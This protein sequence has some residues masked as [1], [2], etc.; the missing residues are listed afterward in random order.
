MN[1]LR[2]L[3]NFHKVVMTIVYSVIYT[4]G[5]VLF[6]NNANLISTGVAGI[7]QIV[8]DVINRFG[9]GS[10]YG[11]VYLILNIP[12]I[13]LGWYK[14][15]RKFTFYS[16]LSIVTVT[17][18]SNM[19]PEIEVSKDLIM[20]AIFGGA[21]MGFG[22]G[23]L[24]KIGGSSG[25]TDFYGIYLY[26]KFGMDFTRINTL[27]NVVIIAVATFLYG[28]EI[29]LYTILS[30]YVRTVALDQVFTNNNKITVWIIGEDLSKVS[31]YIN[32]YLKH[33][34]TIINNVEGGYTRQHKEIIM[35]IL[36]Q[37]EYSM[38]V[39]DIYKIDP[40]VFINVTE[41][42]DV[43]GNFKRVKEEV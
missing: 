19:V 31:Q 40:T 9:I 38:L 1:K 10:T 7:A 13:V 16:L 29:A 4:L 6:L 37:Y 17:V 27:I 26:Q 18:T 36:N 39:E 14:V 42:F 34:T 12:G 21:L 24:L 35:T 33:G 8:V 43:H 30:F 11:I 20:N 25:G 15:G 28:T 32:S 2:K 41:T 5:I 3:F 22:I 23:G